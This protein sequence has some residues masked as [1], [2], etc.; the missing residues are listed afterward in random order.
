MIWNV[1]WGGIGNNVENDMMWNGRALEGYDTCHCLL[2][3]HLLLY[4]IHAFYTAGCQEACACI[5]NFQ[6]QY[7]Y[8]IYIVYLCIR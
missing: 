3:A 2:W 4:S 1:K 6:V 5:L 8:I 7:V